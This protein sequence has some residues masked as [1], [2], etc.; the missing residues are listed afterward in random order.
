MNSKED[1]SLISM[2]PLKPMLDFRLIM[3]RNTKKINIRTQNFNNKT[4]QLIQQMTFQEFL[5]VF[6]KNKR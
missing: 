5:V 3:Q 4:D 6:L 2:I 1:Y